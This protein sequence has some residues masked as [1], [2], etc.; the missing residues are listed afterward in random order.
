MELTESD[1]ALQ[2]VALV[3]CVMNRWLNLSDVVLD[4]VK[5]QLPSPQQAQKYRIENLYSGSVDDDAAIAIRGCDPEGPL[6]AFISRLLPDAEGQL[7]ALGRVFSGTLT[8]GSTVWPR[9]SHRRGGIYDSQ[10]IKDLEGAAL[11]TNP[12]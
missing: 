9:D 10:V 8:S 6:M 12:L 1:R 5:T 4:I 11:P 7:Y 3:K 2:G